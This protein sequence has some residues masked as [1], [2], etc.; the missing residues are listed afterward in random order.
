MFL[1]RDGVGRRG[2]KTRQLAMEARGK[3]ER[4]RREKRR[5]EMV[6]GWLEEFRRCGV[7]RGEGEKHGDG[8]E[9]YA[10]TDGTYDDIRAILRA[11]FWM[12][13]GPGWAF[14]VEMREKVLDRGMG[15]ERKFG[16]QDLAEICTEVISLAII[17][18]RGTDAMRGDIADPLAVLTA[19]IG[20]TMPELRDLI[21]DL[22]NQS[23]EQ[24]VHPFG[25]NGSRREFRARAPGGD[26]YRLVT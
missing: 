16:R 15:A 26:R 17:R 13:P 4:R 19:L 20:N 24:V 23:G 18:K 8:W 3:R 7:L 10:A 25:K 14:V 1:E 6:F 5:D 11:Y 9:R 2:R 12:E 21:V 22:E